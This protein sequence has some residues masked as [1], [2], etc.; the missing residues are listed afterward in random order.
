M[1]L[2]CFTKRSPGPPHYAQKIYTHACV[3]LFVATLSWNLSCG[4]FCFWATR[5][6]GIPAVAFAFGGSNYLLD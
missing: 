4:F 5:H 1:K 2:I 6:V 3:C